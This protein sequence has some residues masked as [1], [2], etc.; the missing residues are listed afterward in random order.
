M[1]KICK[2]LKIVILIIFLIGC[3]GGSSSNN[4]NETVS[5]SYSDN[6][7]VDNVSNSDNWYKPDVNTSWQWQLKGKV[8]T[9]YDVNVYDIDLFDSSDELINSL[10][11]KGRKVICY[12]SA[13]SL[14]DWR[15]DAKYFPE[16]VKGNKMEGWDEL[17]IDIRSDAV[18]T[19]M[20]N[21]IKLAKDKGCDGI[22]PDNVDGFVNNTGFDITFDEQ[23]EYNKFLANEAHKRGLSIGLKN[24][25]EQIDKLIGYFDFAINEECHE[26]DE[27]DK[28][29][30]F[31]E[32]KKPVFNAEYN[33]KYINNLNDRE[34][35]CK[36]SDKRGFQTLILP[37]ELDDSFR[38]SCN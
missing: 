2:I 12:F 36:D 9:S 8:N 28:L 30:P 26:Y 15:I 1:I 19:I 32:K 29:M 7:T 27:C 13:G 16:N 10:K 22:E 38:Y 4:N 24:D 21:R 37:L 3:S 11:E 17:W 14:E 20:I 25:L 5:D 35:L 23:L 18:K 34:T 33:E 6:E 31:I